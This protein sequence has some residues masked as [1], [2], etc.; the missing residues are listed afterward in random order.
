MKFSTIWGEN[1]KNY[2]AGLLLLVS[3]EKNDEKKE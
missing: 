1:K 2:F 3:L